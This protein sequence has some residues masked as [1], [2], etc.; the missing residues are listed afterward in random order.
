[1]F[2]KTTGWRIETKLPEMR[3]I[4]MCQVYEKTFFNTK[5]PQTVMISDRMRQKENDRKRV[6]C[7]LTNNFFFVWNDKMTNSKAILECKYEV[8]QWKEL[9]ERERGRES[10]INEC[11]TVISSN[12]NNTF[13]F[14]LF[15]D[16]ILNKNSF[17]FSVELQ[18]R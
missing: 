18:K 10:L 4:S 16:E 15:N 6:H 1:M 11:L 7:R 3:R 14:Y 17:F 9:R 5:T 2:Y 12:Y 13:L 8:T